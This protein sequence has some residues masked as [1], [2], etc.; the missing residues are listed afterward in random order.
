MD[1]NEETV[2]DYTEGLR[3]WCTIGKTPKQV[4]GI[5]WNALKGSGCNTLPGFDRHTFKRHFAAARDRYRKMAVKTERCQAC[6]EE[7][8]VCVSCAACSRRVCPEC[9]AGTGHHPAHLVD[10]QPPS[11][12]KTCAEKAG[13]SVKGAM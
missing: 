12:C 4:E 10:S 3:R 5:I 11:Y 8:P 13:L 7:V 1:L 9:Y 6:G 2:R